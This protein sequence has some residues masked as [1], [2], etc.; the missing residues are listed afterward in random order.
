MGK[1]GIYNLHKDYLNAH[2]N[3]TKDVNMYSATFPSK[4]VS[5]IC[6][7]HHLVHPTCQPSYSLTPFCLIIS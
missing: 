3:E 4:P 6:H 1:E 7:H 2:N 5:Q